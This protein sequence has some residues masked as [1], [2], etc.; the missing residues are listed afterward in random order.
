MGWLNT[1]NK[2]WISLTTQI[3]FSDFVDIKRQ[4]RQVTREERS[5]EV[6]YWRV[7]G[8]PRRARTDSRLSRPRLVWSARVWHVWAT[9]C[10]YFT[11]APPSGRGLTGNNTEIVSIWDPSILMGC[12]YMRIFLAWMLCDGTICGPL[13]AV[14]VLS[15]KTLQGC[16]LRIDPVHLICTTQPGV[17]H[18]SPIHVGSEG[19]RS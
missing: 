19:G 3:P 14:E 2:N 13:H 8:T 4:R 6:V 1:T 17:S 18:T 11:G 10:V 12:R 16:G 5:S 15:M 7:L 9:G